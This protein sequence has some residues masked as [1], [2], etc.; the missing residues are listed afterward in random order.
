MSAPFCCLKVREEQQ[1]TCTLPRISQGHLLCGF[2]FVS[3]HT[4]LVFD[5]EPQRELRTR[6]RK[7]RGLESWALVSGSGEGGGAEV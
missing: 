6:G 4:D 1:N 3:Y 7:Q 5:E 2:N